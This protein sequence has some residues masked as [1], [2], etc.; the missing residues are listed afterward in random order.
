M[1]K[2]LSQSAQKHLSKASAT[3]SWVTPSGLDFDITVALS[4]HIE[5]VGLAGDCYLLRRHAY[6]PLVRM[7]PRAAAFRHNHSCYE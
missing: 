4:I 3:V 7:Y 2:P 6:V 1:G 5:A